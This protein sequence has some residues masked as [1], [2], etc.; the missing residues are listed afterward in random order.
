MIEVASQ[1]TVPIVSL[2]RA[3]RPKQWVKNAVLFAGILFT[4]NHGHPASDW[5]HVFAGVLVFCL[6]SSSIYLVNDIADVEQD[7]LHPK[8]RFRPIAAGQ[9]TIPTAIATAIVVGGAGLAGALALG[10]PFAVVAG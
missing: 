9:V 7:R 1:M 4:L 8:K 6:L 10:R 3:L 2:F 5:F